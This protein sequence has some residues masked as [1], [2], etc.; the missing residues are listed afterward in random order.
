MLGDVRH[1]KVDAPKTRDHPGWH[2]RILSRNMASVDK[3]G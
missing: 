1:P 2:P 3:A